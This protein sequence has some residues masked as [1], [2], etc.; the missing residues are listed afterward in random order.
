MAV[1]S[2]MLSSSL[3]ALHLMVWCCA[4]QACCELDRYSDCGAVTDGASPR[5]ECHQERH[6]TADCQCG[7]CSFAPPRRIVG[8]SFAPIFQPC[9]AWSADAG[10]SLSESRFHHQLHG[11]SRLTPAVRLHLANQVLLI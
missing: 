7:K 2:R 6:S 11:K 1:F 3:L 8:T 5:C 9:V 10:L 4:C